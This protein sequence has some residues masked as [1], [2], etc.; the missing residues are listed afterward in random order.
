M[1]DES[2]AVI[3]YDASGNPIGVSG[4]RLYTDAQQGTAAALAGAWPVKITD[5]LYTAGVDA[6]NAIYVGGKSAPG[7]VPSSN[8]VSV[9][10]IDNNG[11]KRTLRTDSLGR[12]ITTQDNPLAVEMEIAYDAIYNAGGTGWFE[13][14]D[15]EIPAS[16]KFNVALFGAFCDDNRM[17]ARFAK[18]VIGG[19]YNIG[20]STFTDVGT[21]AA[22]GFA[23]YLDIEVTSLIGNAD[24]ALSITY[25]N[26]NN[27]AGRTA[28]V[29]VA[30][31]S[32]AGTKW[33]AVLQA[34]DIGLRDITAVTRV[35]GL[36]GTVQLN[37]GTRLCEIRC[38]AADTPYNLFPSRDSMIVR[39]GELLDLDFFVNGASNVRRVIRTIG[40]LEPL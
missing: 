3:L 34:G 38:T 6:Q 13:G 32:T 37:M 20:T 11:F 10:G 4:N 8:P 22:P 40:V 5:G 24:S 19:S 28:T 31:N 7:S 16:Y 9:S 27:V 29:T 36:T 25:V 26:Q 39:A 1:S 14:L 18:T 33:L 35:G 23:S 15:Y 21:I 12:L 2:P 17:T 30:K